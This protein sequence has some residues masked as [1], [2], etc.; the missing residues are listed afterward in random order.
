LARKNINIQGTTG[1]IFLQKHI[2]FRAKKLPKDLI[3]N[4]MPKGKT[5]EE[6]DQNF[7]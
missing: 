7:N 5:A 2:H 1:P 4:I 3:K 6:S